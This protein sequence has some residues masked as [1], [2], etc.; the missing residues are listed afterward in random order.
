MVART[1]AFAYLRVSGLGQKDGDG[2]ERQRA[3]IAK[4][5]QHNGLEIVGEYADTHTGT[6]AER[7]QLAALQVSLEHNHH[8][9]RTVVIERLDRLARDIMV[10]EAVVRNFQT[11][12][13][14]LISALEGPDLLATDPSRKFMRQVFG[15][16][17]EFDKE[18]TVQKLRAAKDRLRSAGH[19]A[20]GRKAY[21]QTPTGRH[22]LNL[23]HALRRKPRTGRRRT[24]SQ[25][26][27]ELNRR[28][29]PT[30]NGQPW[31]GPRV[32]Q[33]ARIRPKYKT[34]NHNHKLT[35]P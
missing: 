12:G 19:K 4:Y 16:V 25:V 23:I 15:A 18:M 26:A 30:L 29:V 10:Q 3:A 32:S 8:G 1:P 27:D 14:N 5:A 24:W 35:H 7:P 9:V 2:F 22:T 28:A 11:R 6:E 17:A 13:F 21:A 33:T 34:H 20:E 31:T